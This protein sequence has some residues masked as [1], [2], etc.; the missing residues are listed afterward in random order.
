M[1]TSVKWKLVTFPYGLTN[2][3]S[4]AAKGTHNLPSVEAVPEDAL[5][6]KDFFQ[7]QKTITL[8][9][10]FAHCVIGREMRLFAKHNV[11]TNLYWKAFIAPCMLWAQ[12]K[13]GWEGLAWF[14]KVNIKCWWRS[15]GCCWLW[16][17]AEQVRTVR[18]H[19]LLLMLFLWITW[20]ILAERLG[21]LL[22]DTAALNV[23]EIDDLVT[24]VL[25]LQGTFY[26]LIFCL[27]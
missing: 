15:A 27:F 4:F 19:L 25:K 18:H 13:Q 24:T 6:F 17:G 23:Q 7:Y 12:Q 1:E 20:V 2:D 3:P 5:N 22:C 21:R 8:G 11:G 14:G 16:R 9:F 26:L 10:I